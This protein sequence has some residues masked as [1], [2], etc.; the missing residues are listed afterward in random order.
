[1]FL[2]SSGSNVKQQRVP[3][4]EPILRWCFGVLEG[5]VFGKGPKQGVSGKRRERL[6]L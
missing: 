6:K 2:V 4:T 1:M 5:V 3:E